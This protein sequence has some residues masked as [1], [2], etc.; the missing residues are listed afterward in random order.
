MTI[1]LYVQADPAAIDM[2]KVESPNRFRRMT[3]PANSLHLHEIHALRQQSASPNFRTERSASTSTS[4][5]GTCSDSN[6]ISLVGHMTGGGGGSGSGGGHPSVGGD[7]ITEAI[8]E[9]LAKSSKDSSTKD[10]GGKS[11]KKEKEKDRLA[12]YLANSK[13]RASRPFRR[14]KTLLENHMNS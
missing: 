6:H 14:A 4:G 3:L 5:Y 13:R 9:N 1:V 8:D 2:R 10:K 7:S 11:S 12:R